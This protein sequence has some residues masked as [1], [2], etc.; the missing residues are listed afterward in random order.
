MI[1]LRSRLKFDVCCLIR[2][3]CNTI[4]NAIYVEN[5]W[6]T[7]FSASVVCIASN[8]SFVIEIVYC[9]VSYYIS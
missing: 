6:L 3:E 2:R 9:D 7:S 1:M 4:A 5:R 8:S